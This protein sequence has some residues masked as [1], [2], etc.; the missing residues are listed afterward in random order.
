MRQQRSV[1]VP[2]P[3]KSYKST[4]FDRYQKRA[5]LFKQFGICDKPPI[6]KRYNK[7]WTTPRSKYSA[8]I[9]YETIK[10]IGKSTEEANVFRH[11]LDQ[12][13]ETVMSDKFVYHPFGKKD[14][15]GTLSVF[16]KTMSQRQSTSYEN[17]HNTRSNHVG[18][19][20]IADPGIFDTSKIYIFEMF[21]CMLLIYN[22]LNKNSFEL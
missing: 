2:A 17:G 9:S 3:E 15:R 8:S 5:I 22:T 4:G 16:L 18:G 13:Y 21:I 20:S 11:V 6:K 10:N 14:R 1:L 7:Q 19:G 12:D